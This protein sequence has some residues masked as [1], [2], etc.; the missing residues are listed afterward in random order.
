VALAILARIIEI[1]RADGIDLAARAGSSAALG[2]GARRGPLTAVDPVC[3]MTVV[4][5][6]DTPSAQRDG[7]T[8]YF[9][10]DGCRRSFEQ[11]QAA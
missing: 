4:V 11:Q 3:G 5:G 6:A 1:R 8:T 7:E 9:C 2:A 10:C